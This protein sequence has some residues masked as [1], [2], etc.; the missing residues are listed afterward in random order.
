MRRRT[1]R[2]PCVKHDCTVGVLVYR[3]TGDPSV[4]FESGVDFEEGKKGPVDLGSGTQYILVK[5]LYQVLPMFLTPT[6]VNL[7][8]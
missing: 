2:E 4:S 1:T 3:Q 7:F 5:S 6:T 8:S